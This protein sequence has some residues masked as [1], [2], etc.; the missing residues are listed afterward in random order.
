MTADGAPADFV[1]V[2]CN[3]DCDGP[4]SG[5]AT[6]YSY[7]AEDMCGNTA[8]CSYT[9]T[10]ED[11]TPATNA[12]ACNDHV[13]I[14][15]NLSCDVDLRPELI[16][17]GDYGCFTCF[18]VALEEW[19]TTEALREFEMTVT[20]PCTGVSCTGRITVEDKTDPSIICAD[21]TDPEVTNPDCIFNCTELPLFTT[22]DRESGMIGYRESVIDDLIP[23]DPDDFLRDN[24]VEACGAPMSAFYSD[25]EMPSPDCSAA[26]IMQRQ[27]TVQFTRP[28]GSLGSLNCTQYYAFEP[29]TVSRV[30]APHDTIGGQF[31]PFCEDDADEGIF[32]ENILHM[33][34]QIVEIPTCDVGTDPAS[35]AAFFDNPAT[36]D[37]DT[38]GDGDDP[39]EFDVDCVIENHE[40]FWYAYPHFYT[41]GHRIVGKDMTAM[42]APEGVCNH[43][44]DYVDTALPGCAPGCGGNQKVQR[45]WNVLDWC[46]NEFFTYEQIIKVIDDVAPRLEV[47][48]I[49]ASVDPWVCRADVALPAPMHLEDTC[50]ND[51]T[52]QIEFVEGALNVSGNAV[53][54]YILHDAPVGETTIQYV[55]EDCCGNRTK[56]LTT[57]TVEDLTPPVPVTLQNIVVE[58]SGIVN[59]GQNEAFGVAKLFV[60]DVDNG[61]YDSCTDVMVDIRRSDVCDPADAEWGPSVSFCCEDLGG[62]QSAVIPVEMR[63][64]DWNGNETIIFSDVQLEDKFGGAGTCPPDLII[65]CTDD[66]WNFDVTGGTPRAFTSCAEVTQPVDT[67]QV[68][69]DTEP[70]RKNINDGGPSLGQYFGRVVEAFNPSCGFGA[71]ERQFDGCTQWIIVEPESGVTI[72]DRGTATNSDD[73]YVFTSGF[74]PGSIQFPADIEVDCDAFDPGE[75]TWVASECN[76]VGFTLDVEQFE[77]EADACLKIVNT[78][79]VIDWCAYDPSDPDL[80]PVV[81]LPA[82]G[83]ELDPFIHD[84]GEV[85]GRFVH[86]Q[87]IKVIDTEAPVVTSENV[88]FAVADGCV[89]KA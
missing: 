10:F 68:F 51:L 3:T 57:V 8:N 74:E 72:N 42:L 5:P 45:T 4:A 63:V 16:L 2:T 7:T 55:A 84:S 75:P 58:L 13:R 19:H 28:D 86:N 30:E 33:P 49:F 23:S 35:I 56:V 80:N 9:V 14:T 64:R 48:P 21:C 69:E 15:A 67:L 60:E 50:D 18:D 29:L 66:I 46:T 70:S 83:Q 65:R 85:E 88:C 32:V 89:G 24:V 62:G 20:D 44:I 77:F 36:E 78:W 59:P 87:V 47:E 22:V 25:T 40:G 79:T 41:I 39:D 37:Q 11:F 17:E 38:D 34:K 54:G 12:L 61:S 81:E 27:W 43:I 82:P 53:D 76:L 71:W 1:S 26:T 52:Y 31:I 73:L 6:T